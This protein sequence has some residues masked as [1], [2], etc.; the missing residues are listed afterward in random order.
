MYYYIINPAAGGGKINKIQEKLKQRLK[1]L[2]IAGEF[3]K[4][5]GPADIPKLARIAIDKGYK[6]VVAVGGDGT[7]NEVINVLETKDNIALGI[8]PTGNTNELADLLGIRDWQEACTIL[9]ARKIEKVDLG[10]I[11]DEVF[12]TSASIGFDNLV[13][14]LKKYQK[15]SRLAN[16]V[17]LA[18]LAK[19]ARGYK[20]FEVELEFDDKYKVTTECFNL[21]ISN[22]LFINYAPI[23]SKPQDNI[24]DVFLINRLGFREAIQ[25]GQKKINFSGEN[26]QRVSVF[27]AQKI[28]IKTTEPM[29][30]SADGQTIANTPVT[31]AVS[32]KK[33]RVIVSRARHF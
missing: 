21:S 32:D 5:T 2:G 27:H 6:T 31:V 33:L 1:E 16:S 25:Y 7:I 18:K 26:S 30:I 23:N 24:L 10:K 3:E 9:A 20:P 13:F 29:P 11:N 8:I 4:S 14:E 22:G 17:F 12:V 15:P 28:K 19:A